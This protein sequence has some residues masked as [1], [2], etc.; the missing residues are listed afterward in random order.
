MENAYFRDVK[1]TTKVN[2]TEGAF[3]TQQVYIHKLC[4]SDGHICWK[5]AINNRELNCICLKDYARF[6]V[7]LIAAN[8][9]TCEGKLT[10]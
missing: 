7:A 4:K 6:W 10:R 5:L 1:I 3:K 2:H 9:L 8:L